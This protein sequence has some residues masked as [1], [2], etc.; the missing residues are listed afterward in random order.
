M[1]CFLAA[2]TLAFAGT[3]YEITWYTLGGGGGEM[4]SPGGQYEATCTIGQP[5]AGEMSGGSYIVTGGFW[6]G[7]ATPGDCDDDGD[8]DLD[9]VVGFD[10]A[11]CLQ[12]PGGGLGAG[13]G[14][15]DIDGDNDVDLKD[16][17]WFQGAFTG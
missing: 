14:C 17:A 8:V 7:T 1:L 16:F 9:D 2:S 3:A 10:P 4:S 5:D 13:C 15:L 11:A 6:Q 12:G